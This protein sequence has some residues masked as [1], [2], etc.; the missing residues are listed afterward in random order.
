MPCD[1]IA[2]AN[3]SFAIVNELVANKEALK[4]VVQLLVNLKHKAELLGEN[5]IKI[6]GYAVD[7]NNNGTVSGYRVPQGTLQAVADC[8][9]AI[10]GYLT[11]DKVVKQVETYVRV[12][13]KTTTKNGYVVM[14]VEL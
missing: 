4:A 11:Q 7:I 6:D 8:C 3:L 10:A 14:K 12:L 5:T 1:G 9:N 13:N 2:V